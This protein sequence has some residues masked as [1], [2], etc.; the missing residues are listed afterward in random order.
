MTATKGSRRRR[1][2]S[3][4]AIPRNIREWFAGERKFTFYAYAYPYCAHLREY[5]A[6]WEKENPG[7]VM[8]DGL[9]HLLNTPAYPPGAEENNKI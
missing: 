9:K 1:R 7:A 6:A 8:P 4:N 5:W 3:V 2:S